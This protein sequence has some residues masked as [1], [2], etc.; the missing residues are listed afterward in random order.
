MG[1]GAPRVTVRFPEPGMLERLHATVQA[2]GLTLSDVIRRS[3]ADRL[4]GAEP[5]S[6]PTSTDDPE[7]A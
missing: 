2:Q 7:V 5:D 1:A 3:V 6:A 4:Q